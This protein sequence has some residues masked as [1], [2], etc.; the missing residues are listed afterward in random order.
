LYQREQNY[1]VETLI[2]GHYLKDMNMSE[3]SPFQGRNALIVEDEVLI[4]LGL[5][6]DLEALGFEVCGL[7]PNAQQAISI[8]MNDKPDL[9]VMD[10]Y[11]NGARDGIEAARS[12]RETFGTQVIF[13][14]AYIE[15]DGIIERIHRQ[16]P[17]A[18]VLA[19]PLYG[20]RLASAIEQLSVQS[21]GGRLS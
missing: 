8:A 10:V 6:A 16:V 1:P 9:V 15:D 20:D 17:E 12:L 11:L 3:C 19:K 2:I 21:Q 14:T 13:V 4:A 5:K 18:P 7:A